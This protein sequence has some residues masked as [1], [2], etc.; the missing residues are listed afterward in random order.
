MERRRVLTLLGGV[1]FGGSILGFE[2]GMSGQHQISVS[3]VDAV[4]SEIPIELTAEMVDEA[5]TSGSAAT[6]QI[7]MSNQGD[8]QTDLAIGWPGVFVA[9]RSDE[10]APGLTLVATDRSTRPDRHPVCPQAITNYNIPTL[11]LTSELDPGGKA[12][13]EFAVWGQQG[14]DLTN[15]ISEGLFTFKSTYQASPPSGET[16]DWGFSL[17]VEESS[18]S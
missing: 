10:T 13:A 2:Y 1:G 8:E 17:S 11:L 18:N 9:G 6:V 4:P 15:C 7:T 3:D 12:T 16:F 14:N 5:A